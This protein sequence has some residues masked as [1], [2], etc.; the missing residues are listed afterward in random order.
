MYE[1]KFDRLYKLVFYRY[2]TCVP[3]AVV[4]DLTLRYK[5]KVLYWNL[6]FLL[7]AAVATSEGKKTDPNV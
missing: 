5:M 3:L 6:A 1:M 4:I 2:R 7:L